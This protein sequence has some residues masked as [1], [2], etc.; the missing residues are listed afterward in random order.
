MKHYLI[1]TGVMMALFLASFG[2]VTWLQPA[3]LT[4]PRPWLE[5]GGGPALAISIGLLVGDV[6]LPIPASL[7]MVANG[8]VFG[9]GTGT[10]VSLV[11]STGASW[12]GFFLGR[13]GGSLLDRLVPKQEQARVNALLARWGTLAVVVTRPLPLLSETTAI[14]AGTSPMSWSS[15]MTASL[16]G[17]LPASL[18]YALTGAT[19][20]RLDNSFLVFGLVLAIAGCFWIIGKRM[21]HNETE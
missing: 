7:V 12:L 21:G 13:R 20:A 3:F 2:L 9:I 16:A 1:L 17:A 15:M 6:L 5:L 4:D 19:S 14:I 18:L 10:L 8:A 11:G